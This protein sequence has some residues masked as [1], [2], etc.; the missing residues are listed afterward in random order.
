[1][2][3]DIKV[4]EQFRIGVTHAFCPPETLI[5]KFG[6]TFILMNWWPVH[7]PLGGPAGSCMAYIGTAGLCVAKCGVSVAKLLCLAEL[8]SHKKKIPNL[9]NV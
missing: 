5:H 2:C 6:F 1:M 7:S 3:S 8:G 9:P 4:P